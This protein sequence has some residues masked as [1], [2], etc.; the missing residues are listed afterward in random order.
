MVMVD[1]LG[2]PGGSGARR[3]RLICSVAAFLPDLPEAQLSPWIL[4]GPP[5]IVLSSAPHLQILHVSLDINE[6]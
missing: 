4:S 6:I 1:D 2:F 5:H 3:Q